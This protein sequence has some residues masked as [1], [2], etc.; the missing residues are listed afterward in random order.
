M[1]LARRSSCLA[2]RYPGS[3]CPP[4]RAVRPG[5][6]L[7]RQGDGWSGSLV[8]S[9]D[10]F[11]EAT[12]EGMVRHYVALLEGMFEEPERAVSQVP[13]MPEV[14]RERIVIEWNATGRSIRRIAHSSSV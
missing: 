14:E 9:R 3:Y 8:Y 13:M 2:W 10:L 11:E 1:R 12:I 7:G 4:Y 6:A 5:A